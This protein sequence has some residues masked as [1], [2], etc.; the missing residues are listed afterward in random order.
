M[1]RSEGHV[2]SLTCHNDSL[3]NGNVRVSRLPF[4]SFAVDQLQMVPRTGSS[5][6]GNRRCCCS[7]FGPPGCLIY[8]EH[9][10][11]W[12]ILPS[13][14]REAL[15]VGSSNPSRTLLSSAGITINYRTILSFHFDR[16]R[17]LFLSV[18]YH[19]NTLSSQ[20]ICLRL[21]KFFVICFALHI[22]RFRNSK[23]SDV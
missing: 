14:I 10:Y 21:S 5:D 20:L 2:L 4:T 22:L 15:D 8:P 23:I 7:S 12:G 11:L 9:P 3:E 17:L 13:A 18:I 16:S 6:M 1:P 19:E